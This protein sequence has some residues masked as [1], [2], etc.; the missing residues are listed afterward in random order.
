[1]RWSGLSSIALVTVNSVFVVL[2]VWLAYLA[3]EEAGKRI[4]G[5]FQALTD[6]SDSF[7]STND[8]AQVVSLQPR[9]FRRLSRDDGAGAE[10][11]CDDHLNLSVLDVGFPC[12]PVA[13]AHTGHQRARCVLAFVVK[14]PK[15]VEE[16]EQLDSPIV[17]LQARL[18]EVGSVY[19][20]WEMRVYVDDGFTEGF[21]R[22][23]GAAGIQTMGFPSSDSNTPVWYRESQHMRVLDDET[24]DIFLLREPHAPLTAREAISVMVWLTSGASFLSLHDH[25]KHTDKLLA[26]TWGGRR[27]AAGK[28]LAG[29]SAVELLDAALAKGQT[30][31]ASASDLLSKEV[32]P[33]VEP[34]TLRFDS[35]QSACK[36][37][38][39]LCLPFPMK[40]A[41]ADIPV[42]VPVRPPAQFSRNKLHNVPCH[43]LLQDLEGIRMLHKD[44]LN[45]HWTGT[46]WPHMRHLCQK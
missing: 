42:G 18:L 2:V 33:A 23:L 34:F 24:V 39:K 20:G 8:I 35:Y 21:T 32:W 14:A 5:D 12:S 26:G 44:D 25:P 30:A 9:E 37:D 29:R 7:A 3:G 13:S 11:S 22:A 28:A 45:A 38:G 16:A 1:M 17:A 41:S 19:P 46:A 15:T 43:Q 31:Y 40:P 4:A 6:F 27:A 10:A 36:H